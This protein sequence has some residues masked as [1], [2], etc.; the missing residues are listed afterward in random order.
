MKRNNCPYCGGD[1]RIGGVRCPH[2]TSPGPEFYHDAEE[3]KGAPD[4]MVTCNNCGGTGEVKDYVWGM[5]CPT[6]KGDGFGPPEKCGGKLIPFPNCHG[7]TTDYSMAM[8]IDTGDGTITC[9][10][11]KGRGVIYNGYGGGGAGCV[12]CLIAILL[13]SLP[14]ILFSVI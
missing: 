9:E 4:G 10:T 6:C 3:I 5:M 14:V 2:C 7:S 11:C 13:L 1:E 8:S 12:T